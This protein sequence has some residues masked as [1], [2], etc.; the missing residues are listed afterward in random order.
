MHEVSLLGR[1]WANKVHVD[2]A[3]AALAK[4]TRAVVQSNGTYAL[5]GLIVSMLL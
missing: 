4:V 5:I 2:K 3:I 1:S